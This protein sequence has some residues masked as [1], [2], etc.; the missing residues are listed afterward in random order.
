MFVLRSRLVFLV[1]VAVLPAVAVLVRTVRSERALLDHAARASAIAA[2][3]ETAQLHSITL[4]E[5]KGVLLG[6]SELPAI[7][8]ADPDACA[9]VVKRLKDVNP[10]YANVGAAAPD[11][12]VFCSAVPLPGAVN[13]GDRSYF[14]DARDTRDFAFGEAQVGRI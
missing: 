3:R 11:G 13:V 9:L 5:A 8:D 7:L 10:G 2:V 6:L 12:S 1:L 4:G 14:Q